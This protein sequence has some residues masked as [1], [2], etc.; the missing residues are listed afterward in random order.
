[1]AN[2]TF[3]A[4]LA[5][6]LDEFAEEERAA[7][8]DGIQKSA[9]ECKRTVSE[10]SPRDTG[11]YRQ[12]WAVKTTRTK[13]SIEATVYQKAAPSLTWLLEKGHNI[14][15]KYGQWGRVAARPHISKAREQA[16]EY[17]TDLLN[18]TL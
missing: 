7:L 3:E 6:V 2:N 16:A 11:E 4:E 12:G 5:A 9:K 1:M 8:F 14:K 17:L 13:D 10:L 15:N 18:K